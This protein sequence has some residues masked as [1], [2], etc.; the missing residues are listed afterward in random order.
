MGVG[1]GFS[2]AREGARHRGRAGGILLQ[3]LPKA[4]E[5]ARQADLDPGDA[6]PG[7]APHAA[8]AHQVTEDDAWV[9]GR[10]LFATVADV[11]LIDPAVSAERLGHRRFHD[12]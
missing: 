12:A 7:L 9:E 11:E 4:P 2:A 3:F 6:P 8:A 1:E 10:S 5:R